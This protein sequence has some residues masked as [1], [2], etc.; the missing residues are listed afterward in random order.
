MEKEKSIRAFH[1]ES[2]LDAM[3]YVRCPYGNAYEWANCQ[4]SDLP[5]RALNDIKNARGHIQSLREEIRNETYYASIL[6]LIDRS[7]FKVATDMTPTLQVLHSFHD[8]P[9]T[10]VQS[11]WEELAQ[12]QKLEKRFPR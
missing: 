11:N 3:Q 5:S 6:E 8:S 9:E 1:K 12:R 4:V 2:A 7:L 10:A